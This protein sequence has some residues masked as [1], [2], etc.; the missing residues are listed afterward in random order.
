MH[1]THSADPWNWNAYLFPSWLA[2]VFLRHCVLFP[3]RITL[4]LLANLLFLP[5][6]FSL[7]V[8]VKNEQ[9]RKAAELK[10]ITVSTSFLTNTETR[11]LFTGVEPL[12]NSWCM[13]PW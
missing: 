4:L 6:F 8:F 3:L 1:H 10:L 9:R 5:I 2:G 7:G 11:S 12:Y 13:Y